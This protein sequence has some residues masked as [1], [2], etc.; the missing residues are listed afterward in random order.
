[1]S[2]ETVFTTIQPD[3]HEEIP[4][5]HPLGFLGGGDCYKIDYSGVAGKSRCVTGIGHI[6]RNI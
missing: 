6:A 3:L 5:K 2:A 4:L 1:M